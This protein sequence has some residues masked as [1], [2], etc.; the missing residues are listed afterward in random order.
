MNTYWNGEPT[1]CAQGTAV[2]TDTGAF[3]LYWARVE[4]LVGQRIA[5][6]RVD[7]FAQPMYLDDRDGAGWRKVTEGGS[8]RVGH[9]NVTIEAESFRVTG[10]EAF[11]DAAR[12]GGA[13]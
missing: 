13:S 10:T 11:L 7:Y 1:P 8:P 3:P 2:V 9:R 5:V 12:L 6:V 4:G